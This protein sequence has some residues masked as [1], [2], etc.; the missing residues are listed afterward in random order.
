MDGWLHSTLVTGTLC[1]GV[2]GTLIWG[3][4][5]CVGSWND[6]DMSREIQERLL[7]PYFVADNHGIISD[8][9]FPVG[10]DLVG[11]IMSPLKEEE[12]E[13]AHPQARAA[14]LRRSQAITSLRQACEWGMGAVSKAY[15][16]L[17]LPLPFNQKVRQLRLE[18]IHRLY[19]FRVRT[20]E[21][22]QIGSVF[23][24]VAK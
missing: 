12:L 19:N 10:K 5:N 22:S 9:A 18:N 21:I 14:L 15:R 11:R 16:Q 23:D 7:D 6:G 3:K 2:D 8:T 1:F 20:T 13:R 24:V 17:L 4:H